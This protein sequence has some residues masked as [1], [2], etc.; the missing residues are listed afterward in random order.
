MTHLLAACLTVLVI[1]LAWAAWLVLIAA[2][3]AV[4]Q[5]RLYRRARW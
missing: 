5:R 2:V 1:V 3:D 4:R